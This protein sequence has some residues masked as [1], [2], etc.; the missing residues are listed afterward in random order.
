MDSHGY[1]CFEEFR[2]L[3]I[4]QLEKRNGQGLMETEVPELEAKDCI[5]CTMCRRVCPHQAITMVEKLP[6]F[7]ENKCTGCGL[8]TSRCPRTCITMSQLKR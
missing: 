4:R 1:T 7:D 8:C 3:T 2:G 6:V 5:G